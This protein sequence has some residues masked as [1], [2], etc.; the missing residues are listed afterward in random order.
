MQRGLYPA[1]AERLAQPRLRSCSRRPG[2]AVAPSTFE[3]ADGNLVVDTAGAKDWANAPNLVV[4]LDKPSGTED[5][6]F[7]QGSKENISNPPWS[8]ARSRRTRAT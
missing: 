2:G 8:R 7:G 6:S 5:D 1:I 4:K 3:S